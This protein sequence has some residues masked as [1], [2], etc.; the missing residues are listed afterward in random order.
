MSAIIMVLVMLAVGHHT[1]S[2]FACVTS[3]PETA[4]AW[5]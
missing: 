4:C 1:H 3:L 5:A 2:A